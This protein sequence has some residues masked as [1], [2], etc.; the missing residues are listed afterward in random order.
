MLSPELFGA[1][2][3]PL[4]VFKV[5][6]GGWEPIQT[7]YKQ[8]N[9]GPLE[10]KFF[11]TTFKRTLFRFASAGNTIRPKDRKKTKKTRHFGLKENLF[12]DSKESDWAQSVG[13]ITPSTTRPFVSHQGNTLFSVVLNTTTTALHNSSIAD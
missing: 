11:R 6:L 4:S 5:G 3:R 10:N 1:S 9:P 13:A 7:L 8:N 2:Y 12:L